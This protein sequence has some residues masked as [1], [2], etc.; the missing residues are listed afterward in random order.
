M[1]LCLC[2]CLCLTCIVDTCLGFLSIVDMVCV[3]VSVSAS[4]SV[5][6]AP[7]ISAKQIAFIGLGVPLGVSWTDQNRHPQ[8]S[9]IN[10]QNKLI[11]AASELVR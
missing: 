10:N 7:V 4:V 8:L 6:D 5:S 2:L 11:P 9:K 3:S 1:C